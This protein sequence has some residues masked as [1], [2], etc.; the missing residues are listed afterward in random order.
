L[1]SVSNFAARKT[2]WEMREFIRRAKNL[3]S[4]G[5]NDQWLQ[6]ENAEI[7]SAIQK[8]EARYGLIPNERSWS[9]K[10][11]LEACGEV[12]FL[13][14]NYFF[15]SEHAHGSFMGLTVRHE[16]RHTLVVLQSV[17]G[18]LIMGAGFAAQ[19]V[20]TATPQRHVDKSVELMGELLQLMQ[21]GALRTT[22]EESDPERS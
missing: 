11:I 17:L 2:I 20:P 12:A 13:K 9:I 14:T 1:Q 5:P 22:R 18:T 19:V 4:T 15:L 16:G 6:A 10:R 8:I 21:S 3:G 7:L